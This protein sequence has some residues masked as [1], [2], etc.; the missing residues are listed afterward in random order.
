MA[1]AV[2]SNIIKDFFNKSKGNSFAKNL[3]NGIL[4]LRNE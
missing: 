1:L 3:K 2:I 4:Q